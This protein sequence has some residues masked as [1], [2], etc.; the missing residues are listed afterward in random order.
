[1]FPTGNEEDDAMQEHFERISDVDLEDL[2]LYMFSGLR[3]TVDDY[4]PLMWLANAFGVRLE[5]ARLDSLFTGRAAHCNICIESRI[6]GHFS[7]FLQR[8]I[9][10]L[11]VNLRVLLHL[12]LT[13]IGVMF[14]RS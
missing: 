1:M 8:S 10:L 9:L 13:Y 3:S 11:C 5:N 14:R 7:I 6:C 2:V 12:L 4:M